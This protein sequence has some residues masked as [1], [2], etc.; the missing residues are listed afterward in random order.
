MMKYRVLI[1]FLWIFKFFFYMVFGKF[2][3][4]VYFFDGDKKNEMNV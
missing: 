3:V 1:V 2:I 4:I